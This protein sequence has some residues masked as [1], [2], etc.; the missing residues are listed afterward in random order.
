LHVEDDSYEYIDKFAFLNLD[1][2]LVDTYEDSCDSCGNDASF[3]EDHDYAFVNNV[4]VSD[5]YMFHQ[6]KAHVNPDWILID[7]QSTPDIFCNKAL[8]SNIRESDKSIL[9]HRN[10]GKRLVS[11]VGTL[12]NYREVWYK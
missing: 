9:I 8:L 4:D 6:S 12:K 7:N 10:A 3:E 5:K 1:L 11:Q 2:A